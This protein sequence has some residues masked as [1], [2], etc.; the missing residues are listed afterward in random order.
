MINIF[1]I[2]P[3]LVTTGLA[4]QEIR[5]KAGNLPVNSSD[6]LKNPKVPSLLLGAAGSKDAR[7]SQL[8]F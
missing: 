3:C 1:F 6:R 5:N 2:V 8:S 4:G 7:S